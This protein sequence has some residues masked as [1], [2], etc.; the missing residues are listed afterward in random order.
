MKKS[1]LFYTSLSAFLMA[2]FIACGDDSGSSSE[3]P[4]K[5]SGLATVETF[6]DL[7]H[8]TKSHYG[9]IVFVEEESAYFECT[10]EDWVEVDSAKVDSLLATSSSSG[11][12]DKPKSSSSVKA[13]SSEVAKVETKKVD[14]VT[15]SGLAQK[16]PYASGSAVTVYG[17][18]SALEV[19]K[20]K[21][22]GKVSGDSGAFKVEKIVL[23]S[24]FALVQVSGFYANEISGKN[25][26]GTKTT[27]NAIVDLSAGK[28]VK[29]NVNLFTELEYARVKHLVTAEKFNVPA[30]KK[31]ATKELLAVFGA[32]AGDDLTATSLSLAD[33]GTAGKALLAASILLQGDL[34]ASKFGLRLG[35]VGDLFASTGS[36]DSDTLRAA[37]ADWASKADSV[38]N[39]AAIRK[40]VKDMKLAAAVPDFEKVL[41]TFWTA[42]YKLGACTDSLE[43]TIKKNEN[44]LSDNYGAGYACTSKHWHKS[45]V[46]DTEL[47]LCT[48]KKEGEYKEYKGGKETEYYVCRTGTWQKISAT[49]YELKECTDKRENEYVKAKSGEYFVCTGKQWLEIDDITYELKL[50]TES[51]NQE[52]VETEKSGNYICEWD[53]KDGSWRQL[54]DLESGL[55]VCVNNKEL[56]GQFKELD[57][58]FYIC[59]AS[60]WTTTDSASFALKALCTKDSVV[61]KVDDKDEFYMCMDG[62]WKE[63]YSAY[64]EKGFCNKSNDSTIVQTTNNECYACIENEWKAQASSV[65]KTKTFCNPSIDSTFK[66]G[67]ACVHNS[68][69][70]YYWRTQSDAEKANNAFCTKRNKDTTNVQNG[71]TCLIRDNVLKWREA[72]VAEKATGKVCHRGTAT[73]VNGDKIESGYVCDYLYEADGYPTSGFQ[74][75]EATSEEKA[76]GLLCNGTQIYVV[77]NGYACDGVYIG[78][79]GQKI[80]WRP[81][82][83]AENDAG[84]VCRKNYKNK[85]DTVVHQY[86]CS[87]DGT[88]SNCGTDESCQ[89]SWRSATNP[90]IALGGVCSSYSSHITIYANYVCGE[91]GQWREA[92]SYEKATNSVCNKKIVY[93]IADSIVCDV[94]NSSY[95]WRR[96]TDTESKVGKVCTGE[97]FKLFTRYK[98]GLLTWN[99]RCVDTLEHKW[100]AWVYDTILDSRESGEPKSYRILDALIPGDKFKRTTTIMVDNFNF[101]GDGAGN[102]NQAWWCYNSSSNTSN[103]A[104]CEGQGSLYHWTAPVDLG[105]KYLND[106]AEFSLPRQGICP[107]G[108]H[109]PDYSELKKLNFSAEYGTMPG[110]QKGSYVYTEKKFEAEPC[111]WTTT[112]NKP[113]GESNTVNALSYAP[114]SSGTMQEKSRDKD[115]GCYLRCIKDSN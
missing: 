114:D 17:L 11:D 48:A 51:R 115:D 67:F 102:H 4:S 35:D 93:T 27:L 83:S 75:R 15:V 110:S 25:T 50:C 12:E 37:L 55:G 56:E 101:H 54:D 87:Y 18:D 91:N 20:T 92:T 2:T 28:T 29:A 44:K 45:T 6:E 88:N 33:T 47:G 78:Y 103:A 66:D 61:K 8:C 31:R 3:E 107:D 59:T 34:S 100:N 104:D 89:Y 16:G 99:Y 43:E 57:G 79:V 96:M 69:K 65:C 19:T 74:W 41:Y 10:S 39:F 21:F 23:P 82:T 113:S 52:V 9:E 111:W 108:W 58:A 62:T 85:L 24:Q 26:S 86:I 5:S 90:E 32:K 98:S 60:G 94:S 80:S 64:Y 77:K 95:Q 68:S 7:V 112:Q 84:Y 63:T 49:Q 40:N 76:T 30:A 105:T 22:T 97:T 53:G 1:I 71:Y 14:S 73:Y 72:S 109:V 46:L 106:R 42:E 36:L 70:E 38:D 81:A 13:D